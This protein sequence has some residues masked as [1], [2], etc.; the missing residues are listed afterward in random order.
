M[1]SPKFIGNSKLTKQGQAT[2][3][4]EG[5]RSLDLSPDADVF[6]YQVGDTL[7]LVKDLVA[8]K[9]LQVTATKKRG[10]R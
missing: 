4:Q 10:T 5:R 1:E 9:D 6:W 7:V 2:I 8:P 3:P